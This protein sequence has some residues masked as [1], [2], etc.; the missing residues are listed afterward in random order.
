MA[1]VIKKIEFNNW[2]F[3]LINTGQHKEGIE[4]ICRDFEIKTKWHYIYQNNDE[5]KTIFHAGKWLVKLFSRITLHP[6]SL[7]SEY[8]KSDHNVIIIHGDTFS[9]VIGALIG[10]RLGIKVAHVES[11]LRSFNLL[12]PFPEE[13]NRLLTF[14]LANIAFCPGSWAMNNL[15]KY[16]HLKKIDTQNNTLIDSLSIALNKPIQ[17]SDNEYTIP[18]NDYGVVS[19]HR[20]ENIFLRNRLKTIVNQLQ[21]IANHYPLIFV[22]HPATHKRLIKTN[23]LEALIKNK[24]IEL[25]KRT[26]YFNF[27]KLLASSKFVITDGGSNQEE[28]FYMNIPTFLMRNTTERQEGL[29]TNVFIGNF[30]E[31][32]LESFLDQVK[33]YQKTEGLL[34]RPFESPTN[35]ICNEIAFASINYPETGN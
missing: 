28:L 17:L 5:V 34:L 31:K 7:L 13:I 12:N 4:E 30:S 15:K 14:R 35:L 24:N 21:Q 20:F 6:E 29:S 22:L 18:A 19:I 25:R 33:H 26:G 23:L 8:N 2:P 10:R 27:V 16:S 32:S 9:T 1:P 11:G 3:L